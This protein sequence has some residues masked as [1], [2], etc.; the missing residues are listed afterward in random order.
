MPVRV[1]K[2]LMNDYQPLLDALPQKVA[3]QLA[4]GNAAALVPEKGA[5]YRSD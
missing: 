3:E 5:Q 1:A 2:W 4:N